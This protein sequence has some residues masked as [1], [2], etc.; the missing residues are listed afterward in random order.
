MTQEQ[1]D[2]LTAIV[3]HLHWFKDSI[4]DEEIRKDFLACVQ[5]LTDTIKYDGW[6]EDDFLKNM[7]CPECYGKMELVCF[8]AGEDDYTKSDVCTQ[9]KARFDH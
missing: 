2:K 5:K 7:I 9:C 1:Q 8:P 6:T 4:A 3:N